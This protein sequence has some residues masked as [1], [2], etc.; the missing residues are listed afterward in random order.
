MHSLILQIQIK[1]FAIKKQK[2][3]CSSYLELSGLRPKAASASRDLESFSMILPD[4]SHEN[5]L[6]QKD[7]VFSHVQNRCNRLEFNVN[8]L[9]VISVFMVIYCN[10]PRLA[11]E[12][13][14]VGVGRL[15]RYM[16][17]GLEK[18]RL[19]NKTKNLR[20]KFELFKCAQ[21]HDLQKVK[22]YLFSVIFGLSA[23]RHSV[24]LHL[25]AQNDGFIP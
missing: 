24:F 5:K 8:K 12:E 15:G 2:L 25:S 6:F 23:S 10:G 4:C 11:A 14:A 22:F 16:K 17:K 7:W 20:R 18:D 1:Y 13:V 3:I 19:Q 21:F 9:F